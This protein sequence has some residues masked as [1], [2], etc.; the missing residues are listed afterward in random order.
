M[1]RPEYFN[2]NA[3][4]QV[5]P[6]ATADQLLEDATC[7]M[8]V[9]RDSLA[10]LALDIDV[11]GKDGDIT[12][13]KRFFQLLYGLSYLAEMGGSAAS[14]AHSIVLAAGVGDQS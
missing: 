14:A 13:D 11:N 8:G 9:V 5:A 2:L 3:K 4:Y 10:A 1:S 7:L 6:G 12:D